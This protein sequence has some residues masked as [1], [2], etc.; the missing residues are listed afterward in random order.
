[1]LKELWEYLE[2][3]KPS[4]AQVRKIIGKSLDKQRLSLAETA[5]LLNADD[6]VLIEAIKA[7]ARTLKE[8]IYGN[9]IVLFAPLYIGNK[10]V[11]NCTCCGFRT[12]NKDQQR[13][14][15]SRCAD[16]AGSGGAGR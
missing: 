9:R 16:R 10:C 12:S 2:R 7:G 15:L 14:T 1:M 4:S 5:D 11:N 13:T 3:P 6:P 8:R